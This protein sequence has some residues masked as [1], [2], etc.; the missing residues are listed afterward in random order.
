MIKKVLENKWKLIYGTEKENQLKDMALGFESLHTAKKKIT[1][2]NKN[3]K[4]NRLKTLI[5]RGTWILRRSPDD[6]P[7]TVSEARYVGYQM[8]PGVPPNT[9]VGIGN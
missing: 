9:S 1:A 6:S 3:S 4:L 2:L 8:T 7:S 5:G